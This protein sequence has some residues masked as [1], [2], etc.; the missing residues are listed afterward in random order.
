MS[1]TT[2]PSS[3]DYLIIGGGTAGLVVANRLSED[4]NLRVVVLESGPDRT[5]DAQVQNPATWATLGGSDLDWKM[6]IVPQPGLNNRTQEHPAGKVLGGSSAINGLFF[7]PPSPAGINAWAKLGNPGWTWESFVPY[8]QKTY[9]L[10]PQGTTEVDL[11]QKTQQEPARGPIQVTYPALADQDNGRLIQAWNDAFQAQGY[12]FTGDFLAQEKSVGTRPYTATIHPQSGLRSAAD[13]AYTSTIADR[14]NL[15]IVTEATVQK[16]LFDATSEPVAATGVEVAWNG[17]VTTIQARKEV[18]LAAGAFHSPKLLE[19]SGIGERN[20]LSALGIPVL[21]DQPGVGENLQNH[22]MAVLPLPLKEHP[23]LEALTPGIQGMAFTRLDTQELETLFAQ[24]AKSGT[25]SEQ[26]LQSILADPNEASAFSILGVMPGNVALLAVIPSFPFSR[27]SI[28]VPSPDP[29]AMPV[30][31]AGV[32]T[33]DVDIEIL[34]RHV[35][36]LQQVIATPPLEPYLQSGPPGD[37]E[38]IKPLLREAMALTANHICGTAAML[39]REAGGVVDQEL[40]V[41]GT[42]NVRV[43]DASVFPLITHANP[44]AT[45]YAVAER[46]AD[47]IRK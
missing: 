45:V 15:T 44:M 29:D 1:S 19:L 6:K 23:D 24:H 39:P 33:H 47:L 22:P 21:V 2:L 46:A 27:G 41:Y 13:T 38:T 37:V 20:R 36:Q 9:S 5:T 4:P 34:A 43:V 30:I 26:V 11:T 17:E 14:E 16:I 18:I 40:K 28:H 32:F 8:L 42:K 7:V 25:Q 31:D 35:R 10:V 12:E 3:A